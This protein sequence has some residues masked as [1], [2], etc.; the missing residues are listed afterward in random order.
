MKPSVSWYIYSRR[1]RNGPVLLY[2]KAIHWLT[3]QCSAEPKAFAEITVNSPVASKY[4]L[5]T[6]AVLHDAGRIMIVNSGG[7]PRYWMPKTKDDWLKLSWRFTALKKE[8][9]QLQRSLL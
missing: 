5:N 9:T 3:Q 2:Q 7:L 6:I 4:I 1:Y 8:S